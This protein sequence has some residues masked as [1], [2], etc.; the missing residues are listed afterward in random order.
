M[1]AKNQNVKQ[2]LDSVGATVEGLNALELVLSIAKKYQIEMPI[3][4][5]VKQVIDKKA[6]PSEA[7]NQL[8]SRSRI[9]E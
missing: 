9:Q 6:T 2:A 4:E 3:C 8:M 5:Q 1:L 7:V